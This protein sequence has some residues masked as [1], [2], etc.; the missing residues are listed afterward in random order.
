[1]SSQ[2]QVTIY[3]INIT[4]SLSSAHIV[5]E[6]LDYYTLTYTLNLQLVLFGNIFPPLRQYD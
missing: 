5:R 3:S 2:A 6:L 1:M 4:L